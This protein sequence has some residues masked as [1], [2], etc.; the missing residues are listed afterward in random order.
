M[1]LNVYWMRCIFKKQGTISILTDLLLMKGISDEVIIA[2]LQ[3]LIN[4]SS[5]TEHHR[6]YTR[7]LQQLYLFLDA[8]HSKAVILQCLRLLVNLSLD[9]NMVPHMLVIKVSDFYVEV[10]DMLMIYLLDLVS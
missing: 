4:L 9:P 6:R 5:S 7:I 3:P 2:S 8:S 1:Q 10:H